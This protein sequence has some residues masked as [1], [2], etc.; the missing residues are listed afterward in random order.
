MKAV[1]VR[2]LAQFALFLVASLPGCLGGPQPAYPSIEYVVDGVTYNPAYELVIDNEHGIA[3][4]DFEAPKTGT[5]I[6]AIIEG[7]VKADVTDALFVGLIEGE[8]ISAFGRFFSELAGPDSGGF[9]FTSVLPISN[10]SPSVLIAWSGLDERAT[11]VL[12]VPQNLQLARTAQAREAAAIDSTRFDT[13]IPILRQGSMSH[14][15]DA[16]V[17]V[18]IEVESGRLSNGTIEILGPQ[19]VEYTL[20]RTSPLPSLHRLA[21]LGPATQ[22]GISYDVQSPTNEF[23]LQGAI[24]ELPEQFAAPTVLDVHVCAICS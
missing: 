3:V 15:A 12:A 9:R 5:T 1:S 19:T 23:R 14:E 24:W 21:V 17:L 22:I 11:V 10:A 4:A 13:G 8:R 16:P 18:W 7:H 6:Y 2:P 20:D